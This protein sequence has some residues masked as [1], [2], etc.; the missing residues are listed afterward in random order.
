MLIKDL[1]A[2]QL[3]EIKDFSIFG[4][5]PP[6]RVKDGDVMVYLGTTPGTDERN[7]RKCNDVCFFGKRGSWVL[8][9]DTHVPWCVQLI[10]TKP[11]K[12]KDESV[13]L[14]HASDQ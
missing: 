10:K 5:S 9:V 7:G 3:C 13:V 4:L 11:P 14:Q 8:Q 6:E 12:C 1:Q 2:G